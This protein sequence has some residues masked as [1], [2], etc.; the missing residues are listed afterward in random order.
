MAE[1]ATSPKFFYDEMRRKDIEELLDKWTTLKTEPQKEDREMSEE[2]SIV[3]GSGIAIPEGSFKVLLGKIHGLIFDANCVLCDIKAE[4]HTGG[5]EEKITPR[6]KTNENGSVGISETIN[7]ILIESDEL[8]RSAK[9]I[10]LKILGEGGSG[11]EIRIIGD[12]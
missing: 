1:T 7:Q 11:E 4:L 9:A 12:V 2:I 3:P 6:V 8:K 5:E 10:A